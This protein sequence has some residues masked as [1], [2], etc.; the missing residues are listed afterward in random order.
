MGAVRRG[1]AVGLDLC[2]NDHSIILG[3][4]VCM[5]V[6]TYIVRRR[7]SYAVLLV[8]ECSSTL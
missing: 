3:M 2:V 8:V 1:C 6:C 7:S 4:Y 5:Y